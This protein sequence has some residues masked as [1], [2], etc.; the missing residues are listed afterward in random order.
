MFFYNRDYFFEELK[1]DSM[2]PKGIDHLKK[3]KK[4]V[5]APS[6]GAVLLQLAQGFKSS[7]DLET[8]EVTQRQSK[9]LDTA[10]QVAGGV[11]GTTK[12]VVKDLAGPIRDIGKEAAR[13][14]AIA[15]AVAVPVAIGVGIL[16][17]GA[18][19]IIAGKI[20]L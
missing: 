5:T 7:V 4:P 18:V 1:S 17:L 11:G 20:Y 2:A 13:D 12:S 16:A 3:K 15:G 8:K 10:A 6:S 14:S 19:G 9:F